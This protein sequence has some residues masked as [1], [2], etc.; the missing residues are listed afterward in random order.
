M[1][2]MLVVVAWRVGRGGG[3]GVRGCERGWIGVSV[4]FG[5]IGV[6]RREWGKRWMRMD[7]GGGG[8]NNWVYRLIVVGVQRMYMGLV[9]SIGY[10]TPEGHICDVV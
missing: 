3:V 9:N 5:F 8:R 10:G 2:M 6:C 4:R 7:L 1:C